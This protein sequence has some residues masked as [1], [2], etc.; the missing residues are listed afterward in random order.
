MLKVFLG[1]NDTLGPNLAPWGPMEAEGRHYGGRLHGGLGA[2]P[3]GKKTCFF[4][5][6]ELHQVKQN[7]QD[8]N[9]ERSSCLPGLEI[10]R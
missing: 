3:P 1:K 4:F 5:N 6:G 2:E 7:S 8:D 9:V 10:L